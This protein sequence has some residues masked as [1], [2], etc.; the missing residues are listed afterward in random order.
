MSK[1]I[2]YGVFEFDEVTFPIEPNVGTLVLKIMKFAN[3]IVVGFDPT[4]VEVGDIV[5][6]VLNAN[7]FMKTALWLKTCSDFNGR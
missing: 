2:Q 1:R 7:Y 3:I 4:L 6:G 5:V